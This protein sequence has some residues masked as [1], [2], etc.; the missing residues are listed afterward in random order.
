MQI[1]LRCQDRDVQF[2]AHQFGVQEH[3][4]AAVQLD[5]DLRIGTREASKHLRQQVCGVEVGRPERHPPGDAGDGEARSRLLGQAQHGASVFEQDLAVRRQRD[6]API[7]AEHRTAKLR[8]KAADL[9]GDRGLRASDRT[10]RR[11][12]PAGIHDGDKG[13][14]EREVEVAHDDQFISCSEC[15]L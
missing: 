5:L 6:P 4:P 10:A 2:V 3:A 8:L 15:T 14:Q 9:M 12:H 7:G 11:G 13:P 1:R